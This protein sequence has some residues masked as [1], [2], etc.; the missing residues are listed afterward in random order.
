MVRARAPDALKIAQDIVMR[1]EYL[2]GRFRGHYFRGAVAQI[3][4]PKVELGGY[5]VASEMQ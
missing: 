5:H 4:R 1:Q 2:R 3:P